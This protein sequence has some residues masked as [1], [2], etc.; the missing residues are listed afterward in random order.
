MVDSELF[1]LFQKHHV[2]K[3]IEIIYD[4]G[5]ITNSEIFFESM[6]ITESL[7]SESE[8]RFGACESS[9]IKLKI[10]NVVIPL[11]DKEIDVQVKLEGHSDAPFSIGRYKVV[12][13]KPTA[14]RR[15]RNIVAYDKMYE[16]LNADV[17]DWYNSVLP[18]M[19]TSTTMRRFR[20]N[21]L[22]YLGAEESDPAFE[23]ANDD[24]IIQKTVE[25]EQM[26]GK[27]V[28][29]AICEI[30]GCFGHID[31]NG[32]FKYVYLEQDIQ[33]LY[34]SNDL[35]PDHAPEYLSQAETGHLY[36]QDPKGFPIGK[37]GT[38]ISCDYEDFIVKTINKLQIRKEENDIG[39][40][41]P[42]KEPNMPVNSYIIQDNF[43]VYGKNT[44]ELKPIAENIYF[45]IR[46]IIYRPFNA[47]IQGNLCFEVGDPVRLRTKFE[48]IESYILQ[49]TLKG[50]QSMRDSFSSSGE[51]YYS[52]DI[53]STHHSIIEL[54]G[55]T[56][57]LDR[58][59]EETRSDL[60]DTEKDLRSTI[61]QTASEIRAEVIAAD[62]ALSSRI[63]INTENII[64]EVNRAISMEESL[65]ARIT[66]NAESI[67]SEVS[68]A[69]GVEN[70]L[71]STI[72]QTA[73]EIRTEIANTEKGLQSQIT[74][75]ADNIKLKVSKGDVSSEIS[76]EAGKIS[77]TS[78]RISI[79]STNFSLSE[80][81]KII[82]KDG[83]FSGEVTATSGTF[84]NVTINNTCT[85]AGETISGTIGDSATWKGSSIS[86]DYIGD[87]DAGKLTSG[88]VTR[89][90]YYSDS[91]NFDSNGLSS[92]VG[93]TRLALTS[94]TNLLPGI[95]FAAGGSDIGTSDYQQKFN[96]VY[97]S[98]FIGSFSSSSSKEI[99]DNIENISTEFC[100]NNV[101]NTEVMS[102]NYKDDLIEYEAIVIE[103]EKEKEKY[104]N[105][106]S[107]PETSGQNKNLQEYDKRI[108]RILNKQKQIPQKR[109]GFIAEDAP[110]EIVSRDRK[111]VDIY[112]CIA[113]TYG[114]IQELNKEINSIK[115]SVS[116]L[117]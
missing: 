36:P 37:S 46:G 27:D 99:K 89:P 103:I 76:Q 25:P 117:M 10:A 74:Q 91:V 51:E 80:N 55:K 40:I 43:L 116:F 72:T 49:R 71:S 42:D 32:K 94:I 35:F 102:Y 59:I 87:L 11:Y 31:R 6:E 68:R 52:E 1:D 38:Y 98:N 69:Q 110:N 30:N 45:K 84:D 39:V 82:A 66:I 112:S 20:K 56:N 100:L 7:C 73:T 29:T 115:E 3:Q 107:L 2:D 16:I 95:N 26:S 70:E 65:S 8:L 101:L 88:N 54:R 86:N 50:I 17:A 96:N 62:E 111:T 14:D 57:I 105:S 13:D 79:S 93:T 78:N 108:K 63:T 21:L 41:Y 4:G 22:D 12:S 81:G 58:N 113:M 18:N 104:I 109:F 34:P 24:M 23:L 90:I 15:W 47:E 85:V 48:I 44:E 60:R 33:G 19:E 67:T 97:A 64:A 106:I 28:I 83:E 114:A 75:N 5:I 77:I 61:S 53:N 9:Q 92:Q